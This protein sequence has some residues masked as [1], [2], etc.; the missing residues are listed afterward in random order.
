MKAKI[1]TWYHQISQFARK[2]YDSVLLTIGIM[3]VFYLSMNMVRAQFLYQSVT[4]PKYLFHK[5]F[6]TEENWAGE[7][8]DEVS[9]FA[10]GA[11]M[12]CSVRNCR[13]S[14]GSVFDA[15]E[16]VL[17]L[18]AEAAAKK[19][20]L[21]LA[22][23]NET[24]NSVLIDGRL[25]K[26]TYRKD[27]ED[28]ILIGGLEFVVI[29]VIHD[30]E[31]FGL[32]AY[33]NW[34]NL[35]REHRQ[36]FLDWT[37][38]VYERFDKGLLIQ[39]ESLT[40][41]ETDWFEDRF[42]GR[43]HAVGDFS[44]GLSY[45]RTYTTSKMKYFYIVMEIFGVFSLYYLSELWFVRRKRDFLIRRMLGCC[46]FRLWAA[47]MKEAGTV[48]LIS[49]AGAILAE[50]IHIGVNAAGKLLWQELILTVVYSF[51]IAMAI[52]MVLFGFHVTGI[53]KIHPT[54][55]NIESAD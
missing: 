18:S 43:M 42:Q 34:K 10:D 3:L 49:F 29:S 17:Y 15:Q 36:I 11:G 52:Q 25:K 45:A 46:F 40:R 4:K 39:M 20:K 14:I 12:N 24:E 5:E 41:G 50:M 54:Q 22:R 1:K 8:L 7:M 21:D 51:G 38:Y 53:L 48:T 26:R 19:E 28:R 32:N 27:G 44:E 47:G 31:L 23:W 13:F 16:V 55:G 6:M 35:D 2:E 30:R 9:A 37:A 33:A